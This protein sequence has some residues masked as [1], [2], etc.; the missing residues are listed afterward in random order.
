MEKET[1]TLLGL[2]LSR[3]PL[4]QAKIARRTGI[5]KDRI[6]KLH[7]DIKSRPTAE[8]IYLIALAVD[9]PYT[10]IMDFLCKDLKLR[11]EDEW[12]K[13]SKKD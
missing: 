8:E 1:L 6:S 7:V 2:Y 9:V 10:E 11:P 12:D 13:K 5:S 3:K 4:S